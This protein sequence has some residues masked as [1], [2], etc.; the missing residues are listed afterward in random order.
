M[1][2]SVILV[3]GPSGSGK[4][5]LAGRLGLPQLRLDDFY[6][7]DTHPGMPRTLGIIDW[8]HPDSWDCDAAVA[9]LREILEVGRAVI[10]HYEIS[11]NRAV[12][13]QV[14]DLGDA[15][16]VICEGIFAP[17]LLAPLR[18]A[19]VNVDAIWLDRPR[20]FNFS[21]RLRRDLAEHR[22]PPGVLV[23]R[24]LALMRQE[25]H[26]RR[27]ALQRGFRPLGM[28]RALTR[29]ASMMTR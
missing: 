17:L 16:A 8:D 23:R 6:R 14:F 11:Q 1:S 9:A 3:A 26:L 22:K 15:P 2:R 20:L 29:I 27:E 4:S 24:G 19:E 28:R 13:T 7:D 18:A 5:R 25:P 21:R 12:G 10:P